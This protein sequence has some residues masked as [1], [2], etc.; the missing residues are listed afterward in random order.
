MTRNLKMYGS[1]LCIITHFKILAFKEGRR[2]SGSGK[3]MVQS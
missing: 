2:P 1:F 3:E